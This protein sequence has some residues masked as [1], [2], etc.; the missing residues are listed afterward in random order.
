[1][2]PITLSALALLLVLGILAWR[3]KWLRRGLAWAVERRL[4]GYRQLAPA[5]RSGAAEGAIAEPPAVA[6]IGGGLAGIGAATT[7]AERGVAGDRGLPDP[8]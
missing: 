2:L 7:L 8:R 4:G 5:P 1:M 3:R 6:V